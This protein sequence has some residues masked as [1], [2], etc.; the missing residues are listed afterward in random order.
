MVRAMPAPVRLM[1]FEGFGRSGYG[2]VVNVPVLKRGSTGLEVSR[3]RAML[4]AVVDAKYSNKGFDFDPG[5]NRTFDAKLERAVLLFQKLEGL[6]VDGIAGNQT[7]GRLFQLVRPTDTVVV[8]SG[9]GGG[10]TG[11]GGDQGNKDE[12]NFP[13]TVPGKNESSPV[14]AFVVAGVAALAILWAVNKGRK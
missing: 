8:G 4:S 14:A 12:G 9:G 7:W 5:D 13:L 3:L 6:S 10:S 1:V 2:E 11:G